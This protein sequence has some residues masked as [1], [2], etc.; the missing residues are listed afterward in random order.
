MACVHASK[1]AASLR[2]LIHPLDAPAGAG[3]APGAGDGRGGALSILSSASTGRSREMCA[4]SAPL[5]DRNHS[6]WLPTMPAM[7][8]CS[9]SMADTNAPARSEAP[10]GVPAFAVTAAAPATACDA[11]AS[12]CSGSKK[13]SANPAACQMGRP[14]NVHRVCGF[15]P[16]GRDSGSSADRPAA[17]EDAAVG[18]MGPPTPPCETLDI[19]VRAREERKSAAAM[20]E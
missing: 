4:I 7:L 8:C 1:S 12:P 9:S 3:G 20:A 19:K 15:A 18:E 13:R 17:E 11:T 6:P 5:S 14:A 2:L 16:T 10:S